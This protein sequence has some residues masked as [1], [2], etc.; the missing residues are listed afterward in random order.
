MCVDVVVPVLNEELQ[1][2]GFLSNMA[3]QVDASG[4]PFPFGFVRVIVV[5]GGSG[6]ATL[7]ILRDH[8]ARRRIDLS[9]L[10]EPERSH[11]QARIRGTRA[12]LSDAGAD[13]RRILVN[14]DVDTRF[15]ASW[16]AHVVH[17]LRPEAG[18]DVVA[19]AGYFPD[20]FWRRVPRLAR[21]YFDEVGTLFFSPTVTAELGLTGRATL[22]TDR[23]FH[24]FVRMPSDCGFACVKAA[25]ARAGGYERVFEPDG[26]EVLG[27][28][29][30]LRF[31]L[32][33]TGAVCSYAPSPWYATSPRR[34]LA[35]AREMLD[36]V[37]YRN[38]MNSY[39]A[40]ADDAQYAALEAMAETYD[41]D[42]LR[43]Y[44]VRNYILL[45]C[46]TRP[47]QAVRHAA[48]FG[49]RADELHAR[50]LSFGDSGRSESPLAIH[51]LAD[52]LVDEY[53]ETVVEHARA[54]HAT[55]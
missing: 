49:P 6:D 4:E 48:Y 25:F 35:E 46:I 27:E 44:V 2:D 16:L 53:L 36:G 52:E 43:R 7:G 8:A 34:F 22:F 50:L 54:R 18:V 10:H 26:R 12:A 39:R 33:R 5:D 55:A 29:W 30:H 28:G 47:D 37:A 38:G 13:R 17:R 15:D 3:E 14:A 1:V 40:D 31:R 23:I 51:A 20:E 11:T 41:F 19:Y 42:G 21:R 24:D 32:D 45:P 9:V